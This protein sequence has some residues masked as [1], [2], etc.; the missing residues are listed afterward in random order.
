MKKLYVYWFTLIALLFCAVAHAWDV[1]LTM[2]D[3]MK[4]PVIDA[5]A[6]REGYQATLTVV[7]E[8]TGEESQIPNPQ[9]KEEFY[10]AF[11]VKL[12]YAYGSNYAEDNAAKSAR[13]AKRVEMEGMR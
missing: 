12:S 2:S 6:Y 11:L 1:K 4:Q 13:D 9:T 8:E 3:D 10:K 5:V 7:D